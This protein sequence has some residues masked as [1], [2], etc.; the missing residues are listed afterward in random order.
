[1]TCGSA[2]MKPARGPAAPGV[3][4]GLARVFS[5]QLGDSTGKNMF[6]PDKQ[7]GGGGWVALCFLT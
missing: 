6:P 7:A 3:G 1:M 4:M 2:H 5:S